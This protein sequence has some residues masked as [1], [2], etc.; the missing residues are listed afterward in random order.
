MFRIR[1][2]SFEVASAARLLQLNLTGAWTTWPWSKSTCE[3]FPLLQICK[4]I[5]SSSFVYLDHD[6][7][8]LVLLQECFN[9]SLP[10]SCSRTFQF[11]RHCAKPPRCAS[12]RLEQV[13]SRERVQSRQKLRPWTRL[14]FKPTLDFTIQP[15]VTYCSFD[16]SMPKLRGRSLTMTAGLPYSEN[17][18]QS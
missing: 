15:H 9:Y 16:P 17:T 8:V 1:E 3:S 14:L 10:D 11:H 13:I 12:Y 5:A 7:Y 2:W 4:F 6:L 18:T